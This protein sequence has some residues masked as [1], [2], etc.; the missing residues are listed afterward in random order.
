MMQA[1]DGGEA[2]H[3]HARR[4][5]LRGKLVGEA[6]TWLGL[7]LGFG[8]GPGSGSGSGLGLGSRLG[9]SAEPHRR[10]AVVG[11]VDA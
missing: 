9:L 11:V 3:R 8:L 4:E 5:Q 1:V 2:A 6:A 10:V 7:G